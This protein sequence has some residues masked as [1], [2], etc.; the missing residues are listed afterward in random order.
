MSGEQIVRLT[1][2][3]YRA[4][5]RPGIALYLEEPSLSLDAEGEALRRALYWRAHRSDETGERADRALLELGGP[6]IP[7]EVH[8]LTRA[9]GLTAAGIVYGRT[10][11]ARLSRAGL[12]GALTAEARAVEDE[13][14]GAA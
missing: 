4:T 9:V 3:G 1:P 8:A 7:A 10:I 13:L 5:G 2:E 11:E 14:R 6:F 12:L